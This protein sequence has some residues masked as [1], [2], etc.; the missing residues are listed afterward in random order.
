MYITNINMNTY[1][2]FLIFEKNYDLKKNV[3]IIIS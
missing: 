2:Y 3:T 1:I